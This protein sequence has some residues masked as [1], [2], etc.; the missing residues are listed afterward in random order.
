MTWYRIVYK[1]GSHGAWT[2]NREWAY[3]TAELFHAEVEVWTV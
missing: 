2:S 3:T 1:D